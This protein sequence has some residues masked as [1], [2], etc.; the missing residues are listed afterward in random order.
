M[1]L[2]SPKFYGVIVPM[3]TPFNEDLSIDFEAVEWLVDYLADKG[4]NGIFPYSTTGEF[5]H[6]KHE[7]GL[8]LV[9]AVMEKV[10]GKVWILPGISSNCTSHSIELG[11]MM[12]DLGVDGAVITPPFFFKVGVDMLKHHFSM[13]AEKVDLP[14]IVYNIPSATGINIPVSLYAELAMEYSNIVGAKVTFDS[15][16]YMRNLIREVKSVRKDFTILTGLDDHLLNTLILGGDGG[17]MALANVVPQIHIE[18]YKCWKDNN[19]TGAINA[20]KKLV[21]L[22]EIYDAASSF[23]TSVKTALKV[24]EAPVK[25]YVRPPLRTEPPEVEEKIRSIL[26]EVGLLK[27]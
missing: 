13:V 20:F 24:M 1:E 6:L 25:P 2:T 8:K 18:V 16:G 17:I 21:K 14:I 23:P 5:I 15:I 22:V 4:V 10:G 7:E 26:V 11:R 12:A 9:K 3:I 19:L 27:S